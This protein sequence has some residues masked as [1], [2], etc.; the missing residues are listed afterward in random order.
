MALGRVT[1]CTLAALMIGGAAFAEPLPAT[2][3]K[4]TLDEFKTFADG[5]MVDVVIF[6]LGVPVTATLKWDW[7]KQRITGDALVDGKK[8]IKVKTKLSFEGEKA[9]S[10][11]E[12]KPSCY[13][14]FIEG[15]KFY[16][17]RDDGDVHATSTLQK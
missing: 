1:F 4:A 10:D 15:D 16:E 13:A 5:K 14:I 2:A 12:G 7:K 6:D 3:K 9:C 17:V 8:K 11:N